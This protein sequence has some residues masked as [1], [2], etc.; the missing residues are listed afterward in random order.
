MKVTMSCDFP[1]VFG[2]LADALSGSN[3]FDKVYANFASGLIDQYP[4]EKDAIIAAA[5]QSNIDYEYEETGGKRKSRR[6]KLRKSR[7]NRKQ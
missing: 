2:S 1:T 5:K 6:N 7:R 3:N 4:G